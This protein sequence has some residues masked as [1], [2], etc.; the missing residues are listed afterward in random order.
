MACDSYHRYTED[1]QLIKA[2]GVLYIHSISDLL[3]SLYTIE[4]VFKT[5]L[6]A[7]LMVLTDRW[8]LMTG[9]VIWP[10]WSCNVKWS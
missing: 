1:V 5:T 9:S 2:L 3:L 8:S 7:K 4:T 6:A 10:S